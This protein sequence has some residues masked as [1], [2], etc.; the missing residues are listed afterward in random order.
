M[1][2]E[3]DVVLA[4]V[5]SQRTLRLAPQHQGVDEELLETVH[6]LAGG[7]DQAL[8][9]G[10]A[11]GIFGGR[12]LAA[13]LDFRQAVPQ[14]LDQRLATALVVEQVVLQVGLRCTTQM[15]PSTS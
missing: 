5:A 13:L 8:D 2:V 12:F 3:A 10:R 6:R 15:S 9:L 7:L 14:R 11:L 1:A 4:G